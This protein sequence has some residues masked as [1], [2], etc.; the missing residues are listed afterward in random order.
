MSRKTYEL[1]KLCWFGLNLLMKETPNAIVV[2]EIN[3]LEPSSQQVLLMGTA[4]VGLNL[5]LMISIGLYWTNPFIHEYLS[6]RPL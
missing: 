5:L 3:E 1:A 4:L 2:N 6:G